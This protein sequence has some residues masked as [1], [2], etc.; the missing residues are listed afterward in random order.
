M[1]Q[2]ISI[3][4][5]VVRESPY[6]HLAKEI[7]RYLAVGVA[8]YFMFSS[9]VGTRR[10]LKNVK[11]EWDKQSTRRSLESLRRHKLVSYQ[12]KQNGQVVVT[13]TQQGRKKVQEWNL[14]N[15]TIKKPAHWDGRWRIVA[16]DIAERRRKGRD[17]LRKMLQ[18]LGFL[19]I[20]KSVFV[21]PYSCKPEI[22]FL[23][24][25]F[26]IPAREVIYVSSD[27]FPQEQKLKKKFH[28]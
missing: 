21:Y 15:L 27:R 20:Q 5:K 18:R 25:F 8:I 11:K 22:E 12:E 4:E 24:E 10:F 23:M 3:H 6:G 17:A 26:S 28:L 2:K 1:E 13:I 9:P 7:L 19:Q 16:F 14:E